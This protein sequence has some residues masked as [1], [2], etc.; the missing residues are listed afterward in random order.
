MPDVVTFS[1]QQ[2]EDRWNENGCQEANGFKPR[3]VDG[4]DDTPVIYGISAVSKGHNPSVSL[5]LR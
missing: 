5:F 1:A 3:D 4:V 2:L